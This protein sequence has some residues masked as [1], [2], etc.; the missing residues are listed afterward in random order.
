MMLQR[1]IAVIIASLFEPQLASAENTTDILLKI[2]SDIPPE[3]VEFAVSLIEQLSFNVTIESRYL[4][5][6]HCGEATINGS[7]FQFRLDDIYN[8]NLSNMVEDLAVKG[9]SDLTGEYAPF[10]K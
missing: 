10:C 9:K 7:S 4:G 5:L 3:E 1:V 2:G 8:G 6:A